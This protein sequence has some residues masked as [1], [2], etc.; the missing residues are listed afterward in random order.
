MEILETIGLYFK[1]LWQ[2]RNYEGQ[3]RLSNS[4]HPKR[5]DAFYKKLES[6]LLPYFE[7]KSFRKIAKRKFIKEE[8]GLIH[9]YEIG[10]TKNSNGLLIDFGLID[11]V[12]QPVEKLKGRQ[13]LTSFARKHKR[14]AP[15]FWKY[16]YQYPIRHSDSRDEDIIEEIQLLL[17]SDFHQQSWENM[18]GLV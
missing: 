10:L 15:A 8:N 2:L 1:E 5:N 3:S 4:S 17:K 9:F 13:S 16:D 6:A 14:L 18:L 12:K 11:P 7:E